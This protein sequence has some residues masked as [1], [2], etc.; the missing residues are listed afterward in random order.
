M[1]D[2]IELLRTASSPARAPAI[3]TVVAINASSQVLAAAVSGARV[4]I[5]AGCIIAAADA[6]VEVRTGS[7]AGAIVVSFA[8]TGGQ[9]YPLALFAI[10][11]APSEA[12]HIVTADAVA[13]TGRVLYQ[14][15]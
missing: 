4:A 15:V 12:L 9:V 1:S 7:A 5:V 2:L 3:P 14:A 10:Y 11:S 6:D 13:I 8:M